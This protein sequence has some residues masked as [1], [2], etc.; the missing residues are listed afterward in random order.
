MAFPDLRIEADLDGW[1]DL[2]GWVYKRNAVTIS[3]GRSN[4]AS[5]VEPSSLEMT[6]DN[7]D[8]RFSPRHPRGP[9]YGLLG[10]NTPVRAYVERG[11]T[12][13]ELGGGGDLVSAPDTAG[14]SIT[15]DIDVRVDV[16]A[17]GWGELNLA[18][19]YAAGDQWSWALQTR[20]DG[21]VSFAWTTTGAAASLAV[22]ASALPV[23][24]YPGR[25]AVRVALDV[26]NGGGGHT[27]TFYLAPTIAGPWT[28]LGGPV[29]APGTTRVFDGAAPLQV[30][31]VPGLENI[32]GFFD[33]M[34]R[35]VTG[36]VHAFELRDGT[37]L[38]ADPVFDGAT[39][40]TTQITDAAGN[41]WRLAGGAAIANRR[42][43]GHFELSDLPPT[44]GS[45]GRDMCVSATAN[46][47]LRRLGQGDAPLM[48][49][50]MRGVLSE[51]A[52]VAYWP[53]E[54]GSE[55]T[56]LAS[57]L[58]RGRPMSIT[59]GASLA[60]SEAFAA[61]APLPTLSD[62]AWAGQVTRYTP[63]GHNQ[64]RFLLAIPPKGTVN[65]TVLARIST[66]GRAARWDVIYT[67]A[68]SGSLTY[69]VYDDD[70]NVLLNT[71][72]TISG[73]DGALI[74]VSVEMT[75]HGGN[76]DAALAALRVG[77][78]TAVM[79]I[80]TIAA[81]TSSRVTSV[82]VNPGKAQLDDVTI[83]HI[84]VH[85]TITPVDDLT[86]ELSGWLG[87]PAGRR[88]ARLCAEAGV[89]FRPIGDL[90]DSAA[91]GVQR[92]DTL[93]NLLQECV[94]ADLGVLFEPREA[95]GLGY[96]T[97]ASMGN[98]PSSAALAYGALSGLTP[99]DDDQ[100]L[101]NDVEVSRTGGSSA[102]FALADGPLS[103][104]APPA[105]V[106]RYDDSVT[107][108]V[109]ADS[110]LGD[111]AA[112]RVHIGTV[113]EARFPSIPI[114]LAAPA[115]RADASLVEALL[116]LQIG[117]RV[118]IDDPPS[119]LPPE[120]ISQLVQGRSVTLLP[121]QHAVTLVGAPASPHRI[122]VYD[123]DRYDTAGAVLAEAVPAAGPGS[124]GA[125]S[126]ATTAGPLWTT[127]PGDFPIDVT[128]GGERA[129]V[130]GV[131]G[132]TSPQ[133]FTLVRGAGGFAGSHPVGTAVRLHAP[134]YRR[135]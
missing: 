31:S 134:T 123:A 109:A 35:P 17:A 41:A 26:D 93:I 120:Q 32:A 128:F 100:L 8:G 114:N 51:P 48:S 83:G 98:Q 75:Q 90:D 37:A 89:G 14:L 77:D 36:R 87:E 23:P 85:S 79:L 50:I 19:K 44:S 33:K 107:I 28:P 5:Q 69:K 64:A 110:Q 20:S 132:A 11:A 78:A 22:A 45:N 61:S 68:G 62:S 135:M 103:V 91:M 101:R 63:T 66:T 58:T 7:R 99:V 56:A 82:A 2:T 52:A 94:D 70:G 115:I 126:V 10:R 47:L 27:A 67:T 113:D 42:W 92:P 119:W 53:C 127:A 30:G 106:G 117:D 9:Y 86:G 124:V 57:A 88:V 74:R 65:N 46:G 38:V 59:G 84:S 122:A 96:R 131:S 49:T 118:T 21:T 80:N 25:R 102:R 40:G 73:Y 39:A 43:L 116:D 12:A 104:A 29:A 18:G 6:L 24:L 60:G 76:V 16:T 71:S 72:S 108:N 121:F 54:D 81:A 130:H 111:Q 112:W 105:G 15:G 97:R 129:T 55:A 13:L 34:A 1:V 133:T 125:V 3:D 4:E 95:P